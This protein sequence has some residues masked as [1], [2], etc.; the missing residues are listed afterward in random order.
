MAGRGGPVS[1]PYW[2]LVRVVRKA[3][4]DTQPR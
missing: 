1:G 4:K 3:D 2:A